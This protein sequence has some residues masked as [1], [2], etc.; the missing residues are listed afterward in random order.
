MENKDSHGA[1]DTVDGSRHVRVRFLDKHCGGR[2]F[3]LYLNAQPDL[4]W[5]CATNVSV[6]GLPDVRML[7]CRCG[8]PAVGTLWWGI[9]AWGTGD[10]TI[11][12]LRMDRVVSFRA[13]VEQA[14][15][16]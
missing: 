7:R 2:D 1:L 8:S 15:T 4:L 10:V 3:W 9:P 14:L 5:N 6:G 13:D 11:D 16:T 12:L